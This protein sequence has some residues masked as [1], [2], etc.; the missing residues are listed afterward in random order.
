MLLN[1]KKKANEIATKRVELNLT[2]DNT[3]HL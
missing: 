1:H 3:P 2:T